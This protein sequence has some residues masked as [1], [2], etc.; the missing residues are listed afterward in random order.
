MASL[1]EE[2]EADGIPL[3]IVGWAE[4]KGW[5]SDMFEADWLIDHHGDQSRRSEILF[6]L[7]L[8]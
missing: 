4:H 8:I 5:P 1:I 7:Q 6:A 3:I 2:V